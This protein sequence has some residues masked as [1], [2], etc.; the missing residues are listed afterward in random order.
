MIRDADGRLKRIEYRGKYLRESRTGGVSLRAQT[1]LAGL[2]LTAN[3]QHG[4]RVSTRVAKGTNVGFQNGRFVLRGRYGKGRTKLNL[5]KSGVSVSSKTSVGTINWFKPRYS[6]A[7]IAG[8]Q[9]R[10]QNAVYINLL[11]SLIQMAFMLLLAAIQLIA[12]L[13]Q[14]IAWGIAW[15]FASVQEW[16]VQR[17]INRI[18]GVETAW[19]EHW[20]D[21]EPT[22]LFVGMAHILFHLAAGSR[23]SNANGDGL[24]DALFTDEWAAVLEVDSDPVRVRPI[25]RRSVERVES[26]LEQGGLP[27]SLLMETAFGTLVSLFIRTTPAPIVLDAFLFFDDGIVANGTRT[28]LQEMLLGVFGHTA[29]IVAE[30]GDRSSAPNP[31]DGDPIGAET[32]DAA[33]RTPTEQRWRVIALMIFIGAAVFVGLFV[34]V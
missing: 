12:W 32:I 2:N 19:E 25:E 9:V 10:G 4:F 28:Q 26:L 6:S 21:E 16:W 11:A 15:A 5:S 33:V 17:R 8:I 1:K 31:V 20:A 3:T 22:G 13:L 23:P 34:T 18:V 14:A 24:L 27:P 30:P 29:G 7:K